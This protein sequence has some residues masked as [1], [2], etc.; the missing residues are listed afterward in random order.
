M[1]MEQRMIGM[2]FD[3]LDWGPGMVAL[4]GDTTAETWKGIWIPGGSMVQVG[5]AGAKTGGWPCM[6]W[7]R[8][9]GR[10]SATEEW[11][12]WERIMGGVG[13]HCL[14][15]HGHRKNLSFYS[16]CDEKS[17]KNFLQGNTMT[18]SIFWNDISGC[19]EETG[20]VR[21][22]NKGNRML[23]QE[24][25]DESIS[26]QVVRN[27][28]ADLED[29]ADSGLA[30][31]WGMKYEMEKSKKCKFRLD[32]WIK[33]SLLDI[34]D[35]WCLAHIQVGYLQKLLDRAVWGSEAMSGL[36]IICLELSAC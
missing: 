15:S 19:S 26:V 9:A 6:A 16:L 12:W 30:Q 13:P 22:T 2:G 21:S 33:S 20:E 5:E 36:A 3:I 1:Y 14:R 11:Q 7:L 34:L 31:G 28:E 25:R 18:W 29:R 35:L 24:N 4:G 27:D 17:L 23:L 32:D 8:A 10:Q